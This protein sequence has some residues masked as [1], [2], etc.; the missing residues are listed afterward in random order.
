[1]PDGNARLHPDGCDRHCDRRLGRIDDGDAQRLLQRLA[2]TRHAGTAHDDHAGA[3]ELFQRAADRDHSRQPAF[4]RRGFRDRHLQRPLAGK[5]IHQRHLRQ[6]ADMARD[7]AGADGDD[8]E[9]L[10]TGS[11]R[12]HAASGD[13]AHRARGTF[14]HAVYGRIGVAGDDEGIDVIHSLDATAQRNGDAI[15][16]FP[17]LDA[18]WTLAQRLA[19]DLEAALESPAAEP[20]GAALR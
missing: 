12:Q 10:G 5:A 17:R 4:S 18:Q 13:A 11:C 6:I 19:D 16:M 8:A 3:I 9:A 20:P 7:R 1:M 14:A 2:V 15:G